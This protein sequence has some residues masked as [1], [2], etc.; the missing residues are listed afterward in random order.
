[1][2]VVVLADGRFLCRGCR[3]QVPGQ[4]HAQILI[5]GAD[6]FQA[7]VGDQVFRMD[8]A[9]LFI[10]P[11]QDAVYPFLG[12]QAHVLVHCVD[13]ACIDWREDT[14]FI[15]AARYKRVISIGRNIQLPRRLHA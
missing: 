3:Q 9:L 14:P 13:P 2:V 11:L 10:N 1:M 12:V 6:I 7:A 4:G 5:A 15:A 8:I